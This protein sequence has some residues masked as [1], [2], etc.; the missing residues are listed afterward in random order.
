MQHY[1]DGDE[2]DLQLH[3]VEEL[4]AHYENPQRSAKKVIA[5]WEAKKAAEVKKFRILKEKQRE[6]YRQSSGALHLS[7]NVSLKNSYSRV[8]LC[9]FYVGPVGILSETE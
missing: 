1:T 3:E 9:C 2:E 5:D 8:H 6:Q 4:R 7:E